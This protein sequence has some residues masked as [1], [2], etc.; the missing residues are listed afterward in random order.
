MITTLFLL[1]DII[2][3]FCILGWGLCS[4]LIT[5]FK[6][7]CIKVGGGSCGAKLKEVSLVVSQFAGIQNKTNMW[8]KGAQ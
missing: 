1:D 5:L 2:A 4:P 7:K 3:I 6:G 8:V